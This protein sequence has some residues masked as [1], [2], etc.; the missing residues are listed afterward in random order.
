MD[1]TDPRTTWNTGYG[2][3]LV[4]PFLGMLLTFTDPPRWLQIEGALFMVALVG[5]ASSMMRRRPGG[6]R[7]SDGVRGVKGVKDAD[8]AHADER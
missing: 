1:S 6:W 7:P 2:L 3:L 8:G 5:V 4:V